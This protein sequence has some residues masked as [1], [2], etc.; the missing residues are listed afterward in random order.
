MKILV[1]ESDKFER[2]QLQRILEDNRHTVFTAESIEKALAL[3]K[4]LKQIK[5][6]ITDFFGQKEPNGITLL[7]E[8][9]AK[10]SKVKFVLVSKTLTIEDI[11]EAMS[12]GATETI[13]KQD[14]PRRLMESGM[15]QA[16][17]TRIVI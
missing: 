11:A 2:I 8:A 13:F 16:K 10:S 4:S 17:H 3:L 1:V 12:L 14:L 7:R 5:L 15:I 9:K 6:V